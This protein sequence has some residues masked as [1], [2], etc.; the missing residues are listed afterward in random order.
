MIIE[1]YRFLLALNKTHQRLTILVALTLKTCLMKKSL[2]LML[3]FTFVFSFNSNAQL[4]MS[5][6]GQLE[7]SP[8]QQTV[9]DIWGYAAPDGTEYALV[10]TI[11]GFSIVSLADPSNPTEVAFIPGTTTTW[12]D[13]KT[14][15]ST[16]YVVCDNCPDGLLVVDLSDLPN[17]APHY[18]VTDITNVGTLGAAHNIYIDEF[19]YAYLCGGNLNNGGMVYFDCFTTPG[20]PIFAGMGAPVYS[21]DVYTRG[22]KM[23]GSEIYAGGFS[24]YDVTDKNNTIA[25]GFQE[26]PFEFTHNSWLS[27][28]GNVL[29]TT[30]EQANAPVAAYDVSDPTNIIELDQF[31]PL[32]TLGDGVVPHNVHVW[33]DYLIIS[34]YSDGCIL[35][36]AAQP[37]NLIEV[38]NF[39]TFFPNTTGFSGAWGAYPYLPSGLVLVSDRESGLYVLEPNYVRACYLEGNITDATN[40]AAISGSTITLETTN[41]VD[42]TNAFGDFKT[43]Y[44]IPGTYDVTVSAIGYEPQTVQAELENGEITT[45]NVALVPLVPFAISGNVIDETTNEPIESAQVIITNN[46]F[47]YNIQTDA[48]GDFSIPT[49]YEGDYEVYAGSWGHK[50]ELV[51]MTISPT[52]SDV[53]VQLEQGYQDDYL[54]DL[55]WTVSGSAN[56]GDWEIAVPNGFFVGIPGLEFPWEP[57]IDLL[58][59]LGSSCYITGP[60][61]EAN[62]QSVF[63]GVTRLIS[64]S[65]D[66]T[67]WLEPTVSIY[68]TFFTVDFSNFPMTIVGNSSINFKV[69]NGIETKIMSSYTP[70]EL[71]QPEWTQVT[72]NVADFITVTDDMSFIVDTV[73]DEDSQFTEAAVDFFEA[74]DANPN[75]INQPIAEGVAIDV[76]PNPATDQFVVSYDIKAKKN[77]F[78]VI[79]NILGQEIAKISLENNNGQTNIGATFDAGIYFVQIENAGLKTVA[80]KIV[81]Q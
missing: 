62:N 28:D 78:L 54:L 55:G 27:D 66:M 49:F 44:A 19:G 61:G 2:Q 26:T 10:G 15:G 38:G 69:D 67:D 57:E 47:E 81:K 72:F 73:N 17:S 22:N 74:Y 64:P 58:E 46:Q 24:I 53:Q 29:Y 20:T 18:F 6:V 37:D 42:E 13:I 52:S 75:A 60:G 63:G 3:F 30:D 23:Y 1:F 12:R 34:Y 33:D 43:G 79:T 35:V 59:D 5:L 14:W 80:T 16:A 21:H 40:N 48:S 41:V 39:D 9:N 36:D 70:D 50:T 76:F 25:L 45:I 7:Y 65:I 8:G 11:T 51:D 56:S 77:A 31:R 32:E 71:M 4:N 68:Y